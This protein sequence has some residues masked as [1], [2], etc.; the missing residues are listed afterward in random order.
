MATAMS[1]ADYAIYEANKLCDPVSNLKLQ[2]VLYYLNVIHLLDN[3]TPLITD[4]KFEKYDYGP[5]IKSVYDEY[6]NY[7]GNDIVAPKQ[8]TALMYGHGLFSTITQDF[9]LTD[10]SEND[11][12]FVDRNLPK[13][14]RFDAFELVE[15]SQ[16]EPQWK[17]KNNRYYD[18]ELT[19]DYYQ[20]PE[21]QFWLK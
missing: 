14:L 9:K 7:I 17:N 10:L 8:H 16:R 20:K 3:D 18:D 13:L 4:V 6:E 2:K 19:N 1:V 12:N 11:H 15:L 21:H 5:S